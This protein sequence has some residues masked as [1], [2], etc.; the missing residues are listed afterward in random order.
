MSQVPLPLGALF[1]PS[2]QP[3]DAQPLGGREII[4]E[5]RFGSVNKHRAGRMV[6]VIN[7]NDFFLNY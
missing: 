6:A 3:N 2:N 1:S 4:N 7:K 5:L